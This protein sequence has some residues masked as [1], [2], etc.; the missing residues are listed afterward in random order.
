MPAA[1]N[2]GLFVGISDRWRFLKYS[3]GNKYSVHVDGE[4]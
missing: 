3:V 1:L 4:F 2:G